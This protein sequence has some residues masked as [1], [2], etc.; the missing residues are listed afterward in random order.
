MFFSIGYHP[1]FRVPIDPNL[2]FEDYALI[3]DKDDIAEKWVIKDGLIDAKTIEGFTRGRINIDNSTFLHDA[4]VFKGLKSEKISIVSD[5]SPK[6]LHFH[7][8]NYPYLGIWSK[9]DAP[10]VCIE[11]WHGIADSVGHDGDF[12]TKEGILSL[13]ANDTFT[14]G[15]DVEIV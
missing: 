1:A 5:K 15:Y 14:C 12:V 8:K 10:F 4:L 9:P 13:P 6:A 2:N 11:P 3:F 7:S